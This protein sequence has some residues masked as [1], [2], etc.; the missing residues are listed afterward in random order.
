MT[1]RKLLNQ[2]SGIQGIKRHCLADFIA[3]ALGQFIGVSSLVQFVAACKYH[4][5]AVSKEV[6]TPQVPKSISEDKCL[7]GI[8]CYE[9]TK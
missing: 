9:S 8:D 7:H 6:E 2:W 5:L 3:P 1:A 4:K